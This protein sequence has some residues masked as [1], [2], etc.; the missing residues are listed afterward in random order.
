MRRHDQVGWASI[1]CEHCVRGRPPFVS[2]THT[3]GQLLRIT[4]VCCWSYAR[5]GVFEEGKS[6][7]EEAS[8]NA[9]PKID[10]LRTLTAPT[11]FV[12]VDCD[13]VHSRADFLSCIH[14]IQNWVTTPRSTI[15]STNTHRISVMRTH[16][17]AHVSR[18]LSP[19]FS[20]L[21]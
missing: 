15:C 19:S 17:H 3:V 11:V 14:C 5:M 6:C 8:R 1:L 20:G 9:E 4:L 16:S 21:K 2:T 18:A 13:R 12:P 10:A 7:H